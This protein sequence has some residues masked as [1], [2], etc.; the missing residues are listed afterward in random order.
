MRKKTIIILSI[1]AV[2]VIAVAIFAGVKIAK[3]RRQF[4]KEFSDTNYPVKYRYLPEGGFE[5]SIK[6]KANKDIDWEVILPDDEYLEVN[7]SKF[8]RKTKFTVTPKGAGL[9]TIRFSKTIDV[10][11][12]KVSKVSIDYDILVREASDRLYINI[13]GEGNLQ[14]RD[15][16]IGAGTDNPVI[17]CGEADF[18]DNPD[19]IPGNVYFVNGIGDWEI[20]SPD[21]SVAVAQYIEEDKE[22]YSVAIDVIGEEVEDNYTLTDAVS[23]EEEEKK[24]SNIEQ[25]DPITYDKSYIASP[26][27]AE[28]SGTDADSPVEI[29]GEGKLSFVSK[30]LGINRIEKVV[31][32]SDGHV[33]FSEAEDEK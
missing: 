24:S 25:V 16:V 22:Y 21:Y 33:S 28:A 2:V 11:G 6:D 19:G 10:A 27:V 7:T 17:L 15:D 14:E 3:Y 23:E 29:V 4:N 26:T 18:E 8:G 1:I 9:T 5:Y 12:I 31:F 20:T 32:Y 13:L 30:K